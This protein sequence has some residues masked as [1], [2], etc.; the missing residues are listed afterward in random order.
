M[1]SSRSM[2]QNSSI[3]GRQLLVDRMDE[4]LIHNMRFLFDLIFEL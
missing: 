4:E 2:I 3:T 1:A